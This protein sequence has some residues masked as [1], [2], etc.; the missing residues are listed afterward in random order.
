[1]SCLEYRKLIK[2]GNSSHVISI[3]NK[4][5]K[6][7]RLNK[8]DVLFLEE[9][10]NNEIIIT[11]NND[12]NKTEK[13]SS[14]V[15]DTKN[16]SMLDIKRLIISYYINDYRIIKIVGPNVEKYLKYVR[17]IL[18]NLVAIEIIEQSKNRIVAQD[19][20]KIRDTSFEKIIRRIDTIIRS[21]F[22]D[23]NFE[24]KE[25]NYESIVLRDS[26]INKLV[27]MGFRVIKRAL[28]DPSV[29]KDLNAT[30]LQLLDYWLILLKLEKI[31]DSLK[32]I[33]RYLRSFD[34][35]K[36]Q[37]QEIKILFSNVISSYNSIMKAYYNQN[38]DD[39]RMIADQRKKDLF[40]CVKFGEKHQNFRTNQV[41]ENFKDIHSHIGDIAR[42]INLGG[43]YNL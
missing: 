23:I 28:K 35:N 39:A 30:P 14:I 12:T 19:F 9:N 5:L 32:R 40:D 42:V 38:T 24:T 17:D 26:D 20:L 18:N 41:V 6:K 15:I 16:K 13:F 36:K 34:T 43:L 25:D 11:S 33:S 10:G 8:G 7:N 4:W 29:I 22:I 27:Y 1:M 21:I 3:P 31:G 2:F 37:V